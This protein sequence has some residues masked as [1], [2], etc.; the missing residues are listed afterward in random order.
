MN[1]TKKEH[2]QY[3][4]REDIN[5]TIYIDK[6]NEIIILSYKSISYSE[7]E[8]LPLIEEL[9]KAYSYQVIALPD[10]EIKEF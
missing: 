6:N 7:E 4:F 9:K 2:Y 5:E 1:G 8:L 3:L 10:L